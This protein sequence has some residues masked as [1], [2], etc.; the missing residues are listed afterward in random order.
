MG[1]S[2]RQKRLAELWAGEFGDQYIE[3]NRVVKKRDMFWANICNMFLNNKSSVYEV[4]CNIGTNLMCISRALKD[5]YLWGCDI[6]EKAVEIAAKHPELNVIVGDAEW[7]PQDTDSM[8]MVFTAGV[9][10]HLDKVSLRIA[11]KEIARVAKDYVLLIEYYSPEVEMVKYH[12]LDDALFK[13]P[14]GEIFMKHQTK[15]VLYMDGFV[16][17]RDGFDN[18]KYWVF[19]RK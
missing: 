7:I 8:D 15:F 1:R 12:G 16:G 13:R 2:N 17:E 18:C 4:G 9:L 6:N 14:Y 3:R 11:M 10:I 19:R 5:P